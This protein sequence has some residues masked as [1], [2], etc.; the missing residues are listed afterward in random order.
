MKSLLTFLLTACIASA[1]AQAPQAIPYQAVAR[2]AAGVP[3]AN[4]AIKVRWTASLPEP[5]YI[6]K[7]TAQQPIASVCLT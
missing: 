7:H 5:L 1:F 4:Q 6:K 3:L 2:N